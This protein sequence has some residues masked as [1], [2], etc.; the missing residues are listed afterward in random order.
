M[1]F[2]SR[3]RQMLEIEHV[4]NAE[5]VPVICDDLMSELEWLV[6]TETGEDGDKET[7]ASSLQGGRRRR[8]TEATGLAAF[9]E[10]PP[11]LLRLLLLIFSSVQVSLPPSLPPPHLLLL[12]D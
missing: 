3:G 8:L 4:C 11:V 1:F 7:Q 2:V 5:S 9:S 12:Q 10:I 6:T